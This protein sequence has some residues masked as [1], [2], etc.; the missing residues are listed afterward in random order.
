MLQRGVV[1]SYEP[2]RRWCAKFG[3]AYVN[4]LRRRNASPAISGSSTKSS[5]GSTEFSTTC[6]VAVDQ[7]GKVLDV[8]VRS[9]RNA[10]AAQRCFRKLLKGLEDVPRVIMTDQLGSYQVAH[11]EL[12][13]SW[14]IAVRGM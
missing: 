3:Q 11:R 10:K 4:R 2:I 12:M 14:S 5:S 13:L 8:L 1:I 6:G 9:R 7:D